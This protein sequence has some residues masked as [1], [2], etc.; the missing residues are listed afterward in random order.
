[1]KFFRQIFFIARIEWHFF[2]RFPKLLLA[3]ALVACIP[4]F[5]TVIYLSSVWDPA[6]NS[7]SLP[8]GLVNL[9]EG[10]EYRD[11]VFNMG[12]DVANDLRQRHVF[13]FRDLTDPEDAKRQVRNGN[14]A[15]ALFI[16]KDFSSNAVPGKEAGGGKLVVYASEGNNFESARIAAIFAREL[17]H[18]VNEALNERRW[19]LVLSSA[20]GSQRG[21]ERL[22]EGVSE[23]QAGARELNTGTAQAVTGARSAA[24][25]ANSLNVGVDQLING[26]KQLSVGIKALD[27]KRPRNSDLTRIKSGAEELAQGHA[28]FGKGL[29]ELHKG[30]SALRNGAAAFR[31][32]AASSFLVPGAINDGLDQLYTGAVQVENGA[33]TAVESEVKLADGAEKLNVGVGTLTEGVRAM[34]LGVRTMAGKLPQDSQLDALDAGADALKSGAAALAEGNQ[35]IKAGSDR[36]SAGL[37]LLHKELPSS[38]AQP[39]GSAQGLA[40]SVQPQLE[41]VAHVANSGSA[42]AANVIPAALWLGAGIAVFLIH[43][44]VLPRHSQFFYRPAQTLGKFIIPAAIVLA[45]AVLILVIVL[46]VM[47]IPV[48]HPAAFALTLVCASLAFLGI[49]FAIT[50]VMGDAG[51]ALA[52][53][54]LAVQLSSSGG[55]L[56]VELSGGVFAS[57]S[58]WLPLT[59]VVRGIKATMFDAYG[60]A[61]QGPL[62]VVATTGSLTLLCSSW[63]GSWRFVKPTS[64]RP[65]VDF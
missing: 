5:Y 11:H 2:S 64:V 27:E 3:T 44:R 37:D 24:A 20:V 12:W 40:N 54:F 1:M 26:V 9:D 62:L 23:L 31:T 61:W 10:V 14:L 65:A 8:V 7:G 43:V 56:P 45:Q 28:E 39:D 55:I 46:W 51:K 17:G 18:D 30:S 15:F 53:L 52:M 47:N 57:L 6:A 49:V 58:P 63:I 22:R 29:E 35:R 21:V 60:G 50:R 25:G 19:K 36:L 4:A 32:E 34:N 33:K 48:V 59:W 42:F 13:D 38:V 16:P 41:T